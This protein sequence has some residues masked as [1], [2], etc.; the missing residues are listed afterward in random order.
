MELFPAADD[1]AWKVIKRFIAGCDYYIV[2]VGGRYGSKGPR[3]KSYTEMEYDYAV[4]EGLPVLAFLHGDPGVI[5]AN[6]TEGTDEA[7][8]RSRPFGRR[9]KPRIMRS[10]G[11]LR[12]A[13][14]VWLQSACR[15]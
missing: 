11:R 6:K 1:A 8:R 15:S 7:S 2:I 13:F 9:S 14:P 4:A 10:I 12:R 5:P 3:K